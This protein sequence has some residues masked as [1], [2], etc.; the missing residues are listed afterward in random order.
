[1]EA[2]EVAEILKTIDGTYPVPQLTGVRG[3]MRFIGPVT[4]RDV[5][6]DDGKVTITPDQGKVDCT[7]TAYEAGDNVR[8]IRGDLQLVT[9][10]LQGRI[11]AEGDPM[12]LLRI[13]GSFREFGQGLPLPTGQ[14]S[15]KH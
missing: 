11:E 6:I 15:T 4:T 12:L 14:Q 2:A 1:M 7:V 3:R 5:I 13:A 9:S 10:L 8:L